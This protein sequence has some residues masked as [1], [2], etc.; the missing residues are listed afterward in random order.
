MEYAKYFR[1]GI[2]LNV[3]IDPDPVNLRYESDQIDHMIC[4]H[5]RYAIGDKHQF[6]DQDDLW[7]YLLGDKYEK[8]SHKHDKCIEALCN[9][10]K[11][12]LSSKEYDEEANQADKEFRN[13]IWSAI[14]KNYIIRPVYLYSHGMVS[15]STSNPSDP[16]D[17]GQIGWIYMSNEEALKNWGCKSLRKMIEYKHDKTKKSCYDRAMDHLDYSVKE[18]NDYLTGNIYG[19][20]IEYSEEAHKKYGDSKVDDIE[21]F[22]DWKVLSSLWGIYGWD[23]AKQEGLLEAEFHATKISSSLQPT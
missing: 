4:W 5:G 18:Y 22:K 17:S 20:E 21:Q 8:L 1:N 3:K 23:Y 2:R 16:W 10:Y 11:W 12:M 13:D 15:I 7:Q 14:L 19:Y 6:K 9:K